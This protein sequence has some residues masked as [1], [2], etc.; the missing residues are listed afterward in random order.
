M[1]SIYLTKT[2]KIKFVDLFQILIF[3]L[4]A[5][6]IVP[7]NLLYNKLFS[8]SAAHRFLSVAVRKLLYIFQQKINCLTSPA[9]RTWQI[10][11]V[12]RFM[13]LHYDHPSPS[14]GNHPK[15]YLTSLV[16]RGTFGL[17]MYIEHFGQTIKKILSL[18]RH[19]F[20][21][22]CWG[23]FLLLS[24]QPAAKWIFNVTPNCRHQSSNGLR[25]IERKAA[26]S[27]SS[28]YRTTRRMR[29]FRS[30][31]LPWFRILLIASCLL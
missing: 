25:N 8:F 3:F 4:F 29:N 5:Q 26:S 31:R 13:W 2:N 12:L 24:R 19:I 6:I 1:L 17:C 7:L 28:L 14:L 22:P 21:Q 18:F 9:P 20:S 15:R 16:S 27:M 23:H 11:L 10:Y 30:T